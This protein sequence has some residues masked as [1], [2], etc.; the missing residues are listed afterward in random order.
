MTSPKAALHFARDESRAI[1]LGGLFRFHLTRGHFKRQ[2][3]VGIHSDQ[4]AAAAG[5]IPE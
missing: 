2:F 3:I 1:S 4:H 5:K